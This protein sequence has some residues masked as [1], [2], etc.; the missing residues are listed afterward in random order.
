VSCRETHVR[1]GA[2]A[3]EKIV[4]LGTLVL[5]MLT[6]CALGR[7]QVESIALGVAKH[8]DALVNIIA[9]DAMGQRLARDASSR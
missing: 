3:T 6:V 1:R 4:H 8:L 9:C 5:A 2:G 7:E